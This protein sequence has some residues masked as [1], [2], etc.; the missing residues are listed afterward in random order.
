M[1]KVRVIFD[2]DTALFQIQ[3]ASNESISWHNHSCWGH[4]ENALNTAEDLVKLIRANRGFE[5]VYEV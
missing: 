1:T 2:E 3:I 4:K 5:A